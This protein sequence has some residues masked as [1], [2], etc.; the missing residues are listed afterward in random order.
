MASLESDVEAES[1]EGQLVL[2]GDYPKIAPAFE[3]VLPGP[4][5]VAG[6]QVMKKSPE[7]T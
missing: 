1:L 4:G 2:K 6:L 3:H 7:S 5:K